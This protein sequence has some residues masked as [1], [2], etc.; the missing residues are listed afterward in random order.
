MTRHGRN[1][2]QIQ[3]PIRLGAQLPVDQR[4]QRLRDLRRRVAEQPQQ[5]VPHDLVHTFF[6]R[7]PV[8]SPV[9]RPARA[10]Q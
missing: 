5:L 6:V 3:R 10:W 2:Q 1:R 9:V 7:R 4:H 8:L